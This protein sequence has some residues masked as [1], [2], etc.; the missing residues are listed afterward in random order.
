V[1][2]IPLLLLGS[3]L[4]GWSDR[5]KSGMES[6]ALRL[7]HI[8]EGSAGAEPFAVQDREGE[9]DVAPAGARG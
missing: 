1:V 3:M 9:E 4:N 6:V 5:I 8:R 7:V 2:S